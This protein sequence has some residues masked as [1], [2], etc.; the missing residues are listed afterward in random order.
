MG[1]STSKPNAQYD[2]LYPE[3]KASI[4]WVFH[5]TMNADYLYQD[6]LLKTA[7]DEEDCYSNLLAKIKDDKVAFFYN[8]NG[9]TPP[10]ISGD[11]ISKKTVLDY[12]KS[13][14]F[15]VNCEGRTFH[16][17]VSI[18]CYSEDGKNKYRLAVYSKNHSYSATCLET[19][20]WFDMEVVSNDPS[21][22]N[23]SAEYNAGQL[24]AF[25]KLIRDNVV[26]VVGKEWIKKHLF[27]HDEKCIFEGK[28]V[29][30]TNTLWDISPQKIRI[31]F[32]GC[33][34]NAKSLAERMDFGNIDKENSIILTP[35]EFIKA[36]SCQ[37]LEQYSSDSDY[38]DNYD[39]LPPQV[40][41]Y[42]DKGKTK[43]GILYDLDSE[44]EIENRKYT[45]SH[46]KVYCF[47][48]NCTLWIGSANAT[49][50]GLG[51]NFKK[52][53]P[54]G[55]YNSVEC[56]ISYKIDDSKLSE[57][58]ESIKKYYSQ[59]DFKKNGSLKKHRRDQLG[60]FVVLYY[61][62]NKIEVDKENK[63]L[64]FTLTVRNK[65]KAKD[66]INKT[67]LTIDELLKQ[68]WEWKPAEYDGVSGYIKTDYSNEIPSEIILCYIP[69]ELKPSQKMLQI[70]VN[71]YVMYLPDELFSD[72]RD[73]KPLID[74]KD[75]L[76]A[77]DTSL[78][79]ILLHSESY[80]EA[81]NSIKGLMNKRVY[82]D[83]KTETDWF[84][85]AIASKRSERI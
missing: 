27:E 39:N 25:V 53:K 12:V 47:K 17:K 37:E 68:P 57:I 63:K 65:E 32:G 21:E 60:E 22:P 24:T 83:Y 58:S 84:A 82:T 66:Y 42:V 13:R 73:Y 11:N 15:A 61:F 10:V 16:A 71:R 77:F 33:D 67:E 19:A 1:T 28:K 56:L 9:K 6:Q 35:P 72:L 44:K 69:D 75:P 31:H 7:Y 46:S 14:S 80:E 40:K 74:I 38:P 26:D 8:G 70:G 55:S 62:C 51:W 59:F 20:Q 18:L 79:D 2:E 81:P 52:N 85:E 23:V 36:G 64:T 50:R 41:F 29:V 34:D 3:N 30:L 45:A 54:C 76:T 4:Q 49:S 43:S 78:S 48:H 5:T